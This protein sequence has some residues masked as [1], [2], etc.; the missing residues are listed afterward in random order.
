MMKIGFY[1]ILFVLILFVTVMSLL[2]IQEVKMSKLSKVILG[3]M[4]FVMVLSAVFS[5][6][7]YNVPTFRSKIQSFITDVQKVEK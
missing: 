6:S 7:Y 1:S 5:V 2:M 3:I 4:V